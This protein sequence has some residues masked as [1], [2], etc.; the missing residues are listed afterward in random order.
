MKKYISFL[1]A[2]LLAASLLAACGEAVSVPSSEPSA[3]P[4]AES[5]AQPEPSVPSAPAASAEPSEPSDASSGGDP[6]SPASPVGEFWSYPDDMPLTEMTSGGME[7]VQRMMDR[8]RPPFEAQTV[9]ELRAY[10]YTLPPESIDGT[11]VY[12]AMPASAALRPEHTGP[13]LTAGGETVEKDGMSVGVSSVATDGYVTYLSL[14]CPASPSAESGQI[15][16]TNPDGASVPGPAQGGYGSSSS[17]EVL[18]STVRQYWRFTASLPYTRLLNHSDLPFAF[19]L[20]IPLADY[21]VGVRSA[22][23]PPVCNTADCLSPV[24]VQLS[25]LSLNITFAVVGEPAH[26][27]DGLDVGTMRPVILYADGEAAYTLDWTDDRFRAIVQPVG[28]GF[29][30]AEFPTVAGEYALCT[31]STLTVCGGTEGEYAVFPDYDRID[32]VEFEGV[33]YPLY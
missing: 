30:P 27:P 12:N 14:D 33:V 13:V 17:S 16:F 20:D 21:M 32:S 15:R 28:D 25:P 29:V 26:A 18:G 6:E 7:E 23:L 19:D 1:L 5:A 10:W 4:S 2:A 11:T 24:A 8:L 3:E 9:G 22:G 31:L